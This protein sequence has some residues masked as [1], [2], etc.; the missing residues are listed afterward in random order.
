[1]IFQPVAGIETCFGGGRGGTGPTLLLWE[2]DG[3][4]PYAHRV[5]PLSPLTEQRD[6][7]AHCPVEKPG[8][9]ETPGLNIIEFCCL[10]WTKI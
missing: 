5:S 3:T 9:F 4:R 8:F 10:V 6:R 7:D 1:M 2:P